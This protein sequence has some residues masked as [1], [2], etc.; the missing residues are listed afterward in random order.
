[1]KLA[2]SVA[3]A[4]LIGADAHAQI[5]EYVIRGTV[6]ICDQPESSVEACNVWTAPQISV[7]RGT[8]SPQNR[9]CRIYFRVKC[10]GVETPIQPGWIACAELEKAERR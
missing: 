4:V 6:M 10:C 9:M 1:M 7:T 5:G 2:V 8:I 3:L